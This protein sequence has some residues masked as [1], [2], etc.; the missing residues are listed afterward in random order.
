VD[1]R[2]GPLAVEGSTA[3]LGRAVI[4]YFDIVNTADNGK[5]ITAAWTFIFILHRTNP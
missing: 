3:S 4:L 5:D 2:R 1:G